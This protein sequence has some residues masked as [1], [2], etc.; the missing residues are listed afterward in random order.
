MYD[1]VL[2][3]RK[4]G[5]CFLYNI[6]LSRAKFS[7]PPHS[8]VIACKVANVKVAKANA[9]PD[10]DHERLPHIGCKTTAIHQVAAKN[11]ETSNNLLPSGDHL[12]FCIPHM[13]P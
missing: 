12:D 10:S 1:M 6:Q 9:R 8:Q 3:M 5:A 13:L 4:N 7:L 2:K 11:A